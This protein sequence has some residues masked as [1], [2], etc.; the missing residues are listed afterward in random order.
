MR[1]HDFKRLRM[2]VCKGC[3]CFAHAILR[4]ALNI[5]GFSHSSFSLSLSLSFSLL[6]ILSLSHTH[7]RI[8]TYTHP[9]RPKPR[10]MHSW[11][12]CRERRQL[13]RPCASRRLCRRRCGYVRAMQTP[14]GL[15]HVHALLRCH[16]KPERLPYAPNPHTHQ[17]AMP[18]S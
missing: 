18:C 6:L 3:N 5:H 7:T 12:H 2:S 11:R 13:W 16:A 8:H 4:A 14:L 15:H 1:M 10:W 9:A 17:T